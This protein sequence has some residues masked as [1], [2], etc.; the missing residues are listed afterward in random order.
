MQSGMTQT[1]G[2]PGFLGRFKMWRFIEDG[3]KQL[4]EEKKN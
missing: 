2:S 3:Y 1:S 4:S